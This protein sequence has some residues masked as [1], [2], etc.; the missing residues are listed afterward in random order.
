MKRNY[1]INK[2]S[3]NGWVKVVNNQKYVCD[4]CGAKLWV[5]PDGK[6]IYCNT[7]NC[8]DNNK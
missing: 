3:K 8:G 2:R 6:T 4:K 1:T 7:D 5:A